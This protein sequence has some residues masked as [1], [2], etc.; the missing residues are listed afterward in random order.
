MHIYFDQFTDIHQAIMEQINSGE[1]VL[2]E[3][4]KAYTWDPE[5]EE[6]FN[7][8]AINTKRKESYT[9]VHYVIKPN[10]KENIFCCEIQVR[11]LFEE[12][13]EK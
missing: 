13:W 8:L 9:S 11:T 1:W 2:F 7:K 10:N 12:I 4:P 3:D 5:T 6:F